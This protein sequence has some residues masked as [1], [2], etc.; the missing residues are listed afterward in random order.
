MRSCTLAKIDESARKDG[1]KDWEIRYAVRHPFGFQ[2]T[3]GNPG[4]T[5]VAFVGPRHEGGS[6]HN[7]I[8]V[9]IVASREDDLLHAFHAMPITDRWMHLM[10]RK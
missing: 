5:T 8:E 4:E 1:L 3:L 7:V 2:K 10:H 6:P 9:I